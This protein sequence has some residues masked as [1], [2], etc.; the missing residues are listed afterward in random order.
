MLPIW[1]QITG[2]VTE[3]PLAVRKGVWAGDIIPDIEKGEKASGREW[4][5]TRIWEDRLELDRVRREGHFW[6][7]EQPGQKCGIR[8]SQHV[9]VFNLAVVC[10]QT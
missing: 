6:G 10:S 9:S 4:E 3:S 2:G 5:L 8:M 7:R 1:G